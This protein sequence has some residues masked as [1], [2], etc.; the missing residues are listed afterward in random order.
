M[1]VLFTST[2]GRGHVGPMVPL[3][4]AFRDQG[5]EVTFATPAV[6]RDWLASEG[7]AV[8]PV[9]VERAAQWDELIQ[10]PDV[11]ALAPEDRPDLLFSRIFPPRAPA[12]LAD[13]L[14]VVDELQPALIVAEQAE[15]AA[16]IAAALRGVPNV[17]HGFGALLPEV[18]LA[19]AAEAL[20]P[21]WREHGLEPRPH[22]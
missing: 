22:G 5:H 18:R 14:P 20:A 3:A 15:L 9:G 6:N 19:R 21:L 16:P 1:R 10:A 11:R 12:M 4:H 8:R 7:F 13:L 17:T 2:A